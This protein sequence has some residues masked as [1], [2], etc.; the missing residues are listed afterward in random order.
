MIAHDAVTSHAIDQPPGNFGSALPLIADGVPGDQYWRW[1]SEQKMLDTAWLVVE[2]CDT[3]IVLLTV[4]RRKDQGE[5][6][7]GELQAM[8]RLVPF[9]RQAVSLSESLHQRPDQMAA[10]AGV[11]DLMPEAAFVLNSRGLV[12]LSNAR[13]NRLLRGG[14]LA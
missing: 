4:Q 6:M 5:Y 11:I 7:A 9:I 8:D 2:S 10:L 1:E 14:S 3:H 12:V 13:G